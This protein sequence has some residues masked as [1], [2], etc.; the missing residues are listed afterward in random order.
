M[1]EV[2]VVG[3][4]LRGGG[5]PLRKGSD[6]D[7]SS[8]TAEGTCV[9]H[10]GGIE[11]MALTTSISAK[12]IFMRNKFWNHSAPFIRQ[13]IELFILAKIELLYTSK[14]RATTSR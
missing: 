8:I 2:S 1:A 3:H 4:S 14:T 12:Q 13:K 11:A 10:G 7:G 5:L 9:D 6:V